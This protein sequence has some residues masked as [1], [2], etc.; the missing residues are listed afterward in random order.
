M[1]I[2]KSTDERFRVFWQQVEDA[3]RRVAEWP[4]WMVDSAGQRPT[5]VAADAAP[6]RQRDASSAPH[7]K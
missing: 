6:E 1:S 3:S 5:R 4:S 7:G 2:R